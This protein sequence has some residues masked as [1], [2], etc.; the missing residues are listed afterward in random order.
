MPAHSMREL[1][2]QR[3]QRKLQPSAYGLS[4]NTA[5]RQHL[6]AQFEHLRAYLREERNKLEQT[7]AGD[8]GEST[9]QG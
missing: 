5:A 6:D 7:L 1:R 8:H 2:L 9:L 4:V 3:S